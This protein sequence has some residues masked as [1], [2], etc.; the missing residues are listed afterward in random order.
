MFL[1][2]L[3]VFCIII[4]I[5]C[6]WLSFR[7]LNDFVGGGAWVMLEEIT[8][9]ARHWNSFRDDFLRKKLFQSVKMITP[10]VDL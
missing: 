6:R 5:L 2:P 3:K 8:R 9:C 10:N 7:L 4:F 1:E